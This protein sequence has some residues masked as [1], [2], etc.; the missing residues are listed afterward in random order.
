MATQSKLAAFAAGI[1]ADRDAAAAAIAMPWY[2]GQVGGEVNR[3]RAIKRQ[4][5]RRANIN[6]LKAKVMAPT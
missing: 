5:H 1:E 2:S 3:L 4:R 6:L